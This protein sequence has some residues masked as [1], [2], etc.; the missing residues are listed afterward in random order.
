MFGSIFIKD[1]EAMKSLDGV[2][3][4]GNKVTTAFGGMTKGIGKFILAG[5]GIGAVVTTLTKAVSTG[6]KFEEQMANVSTL[7]GGDVNKRIGE[8]S[9]ELQTLQLET[10]TSTDL[11][12]DGLYQVISAFG[13]TEDSMKILETATKGAKAGMSTVTDSVNL[14][15][16]VTKGY[17]D[18]SAEAVQKASD[19]AF[20]T[21]KLG[22]TTFPELAGAMGKVIPLASAMKVSQEELFGAMATLTGVTGSASEVTTQLRGAIQGFAKPTDAMTKQVKA[23]GYESASAMIEQEGLQGSINMLAE[24]TGGGADKMGELFGSVEALNSVLALTGEQSGNFTKKI[25][26]MKHAT[27]GLGATTEA[28]N[29]VSGTFSFMMGIMKQYVEAFFLSVGNLLLPI[30]TELGFWFIDRIPVMIEFFTGLYETLKGYVGEIV[31]LF[32]SWYAENE[33]LIEYFKG[34]FI[35]TIQSVFATLQETF[36]W[37]MDTVITPFVD[38]FINGVS[39]AE[40]ESASIFA[41]I[42]DA[43]W[44]VGDTLYR[45]FVEELGIYVDLFMGLLALLRG[46][47]DVFNEKMSSVKDHFLNIWETIVMAFEYAGIDIY[48]IIETIK[49]HFIAFKNKVVE[50]AL[51]IWHVIEPLIMSFWRA[52]ERLWAGL[53]PIWEGIKHLFWSLIPVLKELWDFVVMLWD[54]ILKPIVTAIMSIVTVLLGVVVGVVNGIISALD[55]FIA[56]IIGVVDVIMNLLGLV[57]AVLT[58]DW[59]QAWIF[60]QRTVESVWN[61]IK[62]VMSGILDFVM[63]FIDGIIGFFHTLF[64]A[65]VGDDGVMGKF[66]DGIFTGFESIRDFIEEVLGFIQDIFFG[67]WEA[68]GNLVT[69]K[70]DDMKES[71]AGVLGKLGDAMKSVSSWVS[72][73]KDTISNITS[74]LFGKKQE[75]KDAGIDGYATGTDYFDGGLA[76]VGERGA[77]LVE[78]PRGSKVIPNPNLGGYVRNKLSGAGGGGTANIVIELDGR[79]IGKAVGKPLVDEIRVR[80]GLRI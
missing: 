56:V 3:K 21:V 15:S 22:Q 14:L 76:L 28:Y 18:T 48:G 70:I 72:S 77:E 12:T 23:L 61:I 39:L 78:M 17:G 35:A 29:K 69:G 53:T 41:K 11:L 19:L 67:V 46:D 20:L 63:G 43:V 73:A 7:L 57:M 42:G 2:E 6:A 68:I 60:M 16:A 47:M 34:E 49:G 50:I 64:R 45:V 59:E 40:S 79:T 75:A 58:G 10:G 26:A 4:K 55:D 66:V 54:N 62:S 33:H 9:D 1:K 52:I 25:D 30:L 8:L 71:I 65:V 38:G 31:V 80:T 51:A 13:D 27:D 37:V 24:A 44:L 36:K 74:K 32:Q 5:A